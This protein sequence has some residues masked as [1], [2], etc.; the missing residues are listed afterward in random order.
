MNP[1]PLR[2]GPS[3]PITSGITGTTGS[4]GPTGPSGPTGLP[5]SASNTGS[6]G[7]TGPTG[8]TGAG[9]TGNTGTSGATGRTGPTGPT[10]QDGGALGLI[11]DVFTAS[12]EEDINV[13]VLSQTPA[14]ESGVIVFVN[15]T[16]YG[17]EFWDLAG[18]VITWTSEDPSL[19]DGWSVTVFY[20]PPE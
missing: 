5:G 10:G 19:V 6:T 1:F 7:P 2:K 12:S 13:F 18:N 15:G 4:T 8:S 9:A 11:S 14:D 17:P 3:G 20:Q 16:F